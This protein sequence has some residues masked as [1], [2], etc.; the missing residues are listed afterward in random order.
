MTVDSDTSLTR[1][2]P[3]AIVFCQARH[4]GPFPVTVVLKR[5][6]VAGPRPQSE[7]CMP[8][9]LLPKFLLSIIGHLG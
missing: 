3:V 2:L 1:L 8:S 6:Q 7:V 4:I 9:P 5:V